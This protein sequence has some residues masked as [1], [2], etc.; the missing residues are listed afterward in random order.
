MSYDQDVSHLNQQ[1]FM[2]PGA[3]PNDVVR[4]NEGFARGKTAAAI[5]QELLVKVE[6]V[7]SFDPKRG[8]VQATVA[9]VESEYA[10][11]DVPEGA[12]AFAKVLRRGRN[13]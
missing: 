7:A 5:S 1:E 2:K 3:T 13:K 8:A 11:G 9:K 6:C 10:D 12:E 4:I